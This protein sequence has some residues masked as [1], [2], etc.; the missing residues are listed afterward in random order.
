MCSFC[1]F[2]FLFLLNF[3]LYST[4]NT[5]ASPRRVY[6]H[7]KSTRAHDR[8]PTDPRSPK[9]GTPRS[10]PARSRVMPQHSHAHATPCSSLVA[11]AG[12]PV[13]QRCGSP[14][15]GHASRVSVTCKPSLDDN[16]QSSCADGRAG[17][18]T[19]ERSSQP[20]LPVTHVSASRGGA[21][22]GRLGCRYLSQAARPLDG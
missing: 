14:S 8:S 9:D 4:R 16:S 10:P 20:P 3:R 19:S 17:H 18:L 13:S 6:P 15:R 1:P 21:L 7:P 2:F 12:H 22:G 11:L 5:A